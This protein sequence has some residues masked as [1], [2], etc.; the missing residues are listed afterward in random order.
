[1]TEPDTTAPTAADESVAEIVDGLWDRFGSLTVGDLP[2]AVRTVALHCILDWYGCAIAGS[3]EPVTQ[4]VRDEFATVTGPAHLV[5]T[6]RLTGV[7][8]AAL[9]NGAAGHAL[10]FDDTNTIMG[11]HPSAPVLPAVLALAEERGSSG[12]EVVAAYVVG[13]EIEARLGVAIGPSHYARGWHTTSTIGVLGAAAAA[14][15][16]LGFDVDA[17]GRA[18]GLA[19]S[20]S[21]GVK[22]NFGTMAKPF[23]AGHAAEGGLVAARLVARGFTANAAAIGGGQG[24]AAA[25]GTGELQ[26]AKLKRYAREWT[27]PQTLFKY[28][29]ACYLTHAAIEATTALLP[30]VGAQP[31]ERVTVTVHPSLTSVCAIPRP[32]TGLESKFSLAAATAFA[33]LG[34]DTTDVATFTDTQLADAEMQRLIELVRV[35]TDPAVRSTASRVEVE[36]PTGTVRASFDTGIPDTDLDRQG[37]RLRAKFLRLASPVVGTEHAHRLADQLTALADLP[38]IRT[39]EPPQET[40]PRS[41]SLDK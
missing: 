27:T 23:H 13:L 29:A 35:E 41:L 18:L 11:G 24:L 7:T 8:Q 12:A 10:D 17:F 32:T 9:I 20:Q 30:E 34:M 39:L 2:E 21:S 25:A 16:L 26:L 15:R 38:D 4:I 19:A 37:A 22:A 31:V 40:A 5:G 14:S 6:D 33:L 1:M 28:H 36:T 3:L